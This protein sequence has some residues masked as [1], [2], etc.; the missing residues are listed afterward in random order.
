MFFEKLSKEK[1][2]NR[3]AYLTVISPPIGYWM[4]DY[5]LKEEK[6]QR[7]VSAKGS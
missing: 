3:K 4:P 2:N 5:F 7:N 1:E 6:K